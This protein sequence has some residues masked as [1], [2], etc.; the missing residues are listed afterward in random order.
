MKRTHKTVLTALCAILL[1]AAS[2]M[3]TLAYLTDTESVTN[4]FTVGKVYI[5]LDEADTDETGKVISQDRVKENKYHLIPG[6]AYTKD[7]TVHVEAGSEPA[8]LFVEVVNNIQEIEA[9]TGEDYTCIAEQL[10]KK[11]WNPLE[12][13]ANVYYQKHDTKVSADKGYVVFENFK[14]DG[15]KAVNN[16]ANGTTTF[17]IATYNTEKY[18]N[19]VITVT[20]YAIQMA[21]FENNAA[22]AWTAFQQQNPNT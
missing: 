22:A 11:G 16:G 3:G 1:V 8:W 6:S 9:A 13:V 18:A 20:A 10:T 7:P 19:R 12:G 21:G 14:I 2:V 5:E 15:A 4:T 17:D